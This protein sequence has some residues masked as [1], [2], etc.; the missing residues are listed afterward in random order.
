MGPLPILLAQI[1]DPIRIALVI[2]TIWF[3][4]TLFDRGKSRLTAT[5]IGLAIVAIGLGLFLH[6]HSGDNWWA[7]SAVFGFVANCL[8]WAICYGALRFYRWQTET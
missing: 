6:A 5:C 7:V 8:I 4:S 1:S 2:F 3:L